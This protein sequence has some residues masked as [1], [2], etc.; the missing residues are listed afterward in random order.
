MLFLVVFTICLT[1]GL[2]KFGQKTEIWRWINR[3]VRWCIVCVAGVGVETAATVL[4]LTRPLYGFPYEYA[5]KTH[6]KTM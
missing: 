5:N 3:F 6:D 2:A 1:I 4:D